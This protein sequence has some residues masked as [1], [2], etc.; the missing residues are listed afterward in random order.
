MK[1]LGL[2]AIARSSLLI[3]AAVLA[4]CGGSGDDQKAAAPSPGASTPVG[5][6]PVTTLPPEMSSI[7]L[8]QTHV[9]G[10]QGRPM[11]STNDAK[12]N[13]TRRLTLVADRAALLMLQPKGTVASLQ[14][15]ARLADG[16]TLGPLA[17]KAPDKLPATDGGRSPY[18]TAKYSVLLPKEWVQ[19]GAR[20]EIGQADFSA[21]LSVA[22]TVTPGTALKQV[23]VP[24][25]LFGARAENSVVPEF[26]MGS[27]AT[28][29][30]TLEQE[31]L[32]KLPIAQYEQTTAGAFTFDQLVVP[33]RNDDTFC[34][35]AMAVG[36]WADFKAID[37]D[38]NARMWNFLG[39]LHG[40]TA[41]RDAAM[42]VGY[43]GYVQTVD[44]GVQVAAS[45]GGGLGGGGS[46]VSGGDYRPDKVY[47]AIFNHE[48]GHAYGLPHADAAADA[49]DYPYPMGT[50]SGSSW[51]YDAYRNQL[52]SPLQ[53]TGMSCDGR[54]V[55]G[56]CYQRTPMSGGDDD[57]DSQAYRWDNFSDYQAAIMQEGFLGKVVRDDAAA[58]GYKRWNSSTGA[59]E[60]LSDDDRSRIA[61][62]VVKLNQQVQTVFGSVSH[63]NASP[64]A[65]RLYVTPAWVANLPRHFDPTLQA[66]LDLIT[67]TNP[68]GWNGYYCVYSGCDYTLAAT[69]ADGT[70]ARVLL[71]VGY[72]NFNAPADDSGINAA[73]RNVLNADNLATYAVNLPA[74]HGGVSRLQLFSTPFGSKW[75]LRL[76]ALVASDLGS[77][78]YPLVNEW[79][80]A[81]GFTGGNGASGSTQFDASVCKAGATVKR[82][83]R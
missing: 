64:T 41:N 10:A 20:L 29:G 9:I 60:K 6:P 44:G 55:N 16:R 70:V 76:M 15:R 5:T 36:S 24:L 27:T 22:L 37:G 43:Y 51:G 82:P 18:A 74:G 40:N 3:S 73:T 69:Y 39:T 77:A 59:F 65:S 78:K 81:A 52:L 34:Y 67:S 63:F 79:T 68:G 49:G 30:Y 35:P 21:P 2:F 32:Q 28:N 54:T 14:V 45:T 71:P 26:A 17:L 12:N 62:D 53:F 23:T 48:M 4:A 38:T 66:D 58:G 75:K 1:R 56:T 42:A 25:Y 11:Q 83:A 50:K 19:I 72:H 80:P 13:L 7:E 31:Y 46:G 8:A 57:R 33:A 61:T 47:S